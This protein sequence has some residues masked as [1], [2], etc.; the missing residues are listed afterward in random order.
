MAKSRSRAEWII[1]LHSNASLA[2]SLRLMSE[3]FLWYS[4]V[5]ICDHRK[6]VICVGFGISRFWDFGVLEF[7]SFG[8]LELWS[9]EALEL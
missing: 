8:A 7:W 6:W 9:F 3:P 2:L 4:F 1:L 5:I